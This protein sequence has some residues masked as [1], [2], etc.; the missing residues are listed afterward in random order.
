MDRYFH[1][2]SMQDSAKIFTCSFECGLIVITTCYLC[3]LS[4][5]D[6]YR[7]N[8]HEVTPSGALFEDHQIFVVNTESN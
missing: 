7:T 6:I 8:V 1:A 2:N 3:T 4:I 5:I